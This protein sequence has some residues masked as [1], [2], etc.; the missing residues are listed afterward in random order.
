MAIAAYFDL[1]LQQLDAIS[2]F[3]NSVLRRK[4][5]VRLPDGFRQANKC[6]LLLRALYGLKE[7]GHLWYEEF[8][9]T[10]SDFGLQCSEDEKCLW[11][12]DWLVIF[13]FVDDTVSMFKSKDWGKWK[14]FKAD[15]CN[16]YDFKDLGD[17]KWFLGVRVIR[18]RPNRTR[19]IAESKQRH[20]SKR[21]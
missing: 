20:K 17:L 4:L 12:N 16:S 8:T 15:L 5:Y 11:Y 19:D 9:G 1:E 7:S 13:F 3:T 21:P 6:L 14:Q 2:A 10:L 18:D